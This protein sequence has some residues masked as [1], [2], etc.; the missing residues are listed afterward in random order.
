MLYIFPSPPPGWGKYLVV[1][2]CTKIYTSNIILL[3][4]T[5]PWSRLISCGVFKRAPA[6]HW[7][8]HTTHCIQSA[9]F[10]VQSTAAIDI[11]PRDVRLSSSDLKTAHK[12]LLAADQPPTD[13]ESA[14]TTNDD[15]VNEETVAGWI[16]SYQSVA[17]SPIHGQKCIVCRRKHYIKHTYI[18]I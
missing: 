17:R 2:H 8:H 7:T 18:Y 6:P 10:L 3:L 9:P 13:R 5:F 15:D 12:F 4:I 11:I 16:H 1:K 14:T